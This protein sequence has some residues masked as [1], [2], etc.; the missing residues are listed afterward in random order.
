M[1]PQSVLEAANR[2][3]VT[4]EALSKAVFGDRVLEVS[5]TP[6]AASPPPA[7]LEFTGIKYNTYKNFNF[8]NGFAILSV[9]TLKN[10]SGLP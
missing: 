10:V 6:N 3:S 4:E 9:F 8:S 5:V 7:D 2:G 1:F